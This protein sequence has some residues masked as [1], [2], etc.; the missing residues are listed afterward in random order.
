MSRANAALTHHG[1]GV[2]QELADG[3]VWVVNGC[4]DLE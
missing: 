3:D 1:Q 2:G 4:A